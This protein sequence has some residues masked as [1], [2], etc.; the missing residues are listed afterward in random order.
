MGIEHTDLKNTGTG[1]GV[2]IDS[3]SDSVA[4][5]SPLSSARSEVCPS[6]PPLRSLHPDVT[7]CLNTRKEIQENVRTEL[8]LAADRDLALV[9]RPPGP[10]W[11]A[12]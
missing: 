1:E 6:F 3:I 9:I 11:K 2:M 7:S 12:T 5:G 8:S 4:E 10:R